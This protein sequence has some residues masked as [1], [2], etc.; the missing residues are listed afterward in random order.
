M[1]GFILMMMFVPALLLG[2]PQLTNSSNSQ[3]SYAENEWQLIDEQGDIKAFARV[4]ICKDDAPVYLLKFENANRSQ[5]FQVHY[6]VEV[7]N[8][9]TWGTSSKVIKVGAGQTVLGDCSDSDQQLLRFINVGV[10]DSDLAHFNFHLTTT[11]P[12]SHEE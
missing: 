6:Q 5:D 2:Q 4:S 10:P 9:P 3:K 8:D 7:K 12:V 1:K 11:K